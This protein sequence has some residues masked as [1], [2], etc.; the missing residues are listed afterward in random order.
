[1]DAS[2]VILDEARPTKIIWLP[3][4]NKRLV[5]M[6]NLLGE[7]VL[8]KGRSRPSLFHYLEALRLPI[9]IISP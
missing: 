4:L 6:K 7:S 2:K 8:G 9:S 1:M 5:R 3:V